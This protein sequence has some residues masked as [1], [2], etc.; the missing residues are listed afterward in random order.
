MK[1][2]PKQNLPNPE[3]T[4]R[5]EKVKYLHSLGKMNNEISLE[6]NIQER[7]VRDD[8]SFMQISCNFYPLIEET[9][10]LKQ[11]IL[12]SILGDGH[13]C[14]LNSR[15]YNSYLS[16]AHSIK[17]KEYFELK[18][19]IL[20]K[21]KIGNQF[22]I[23]N[24]IDPR[25]KDIYTEIRTKSKTHPLFTKYR[26]LFYKDGIKYINKEIIKDLDPFGLAI[27]FMDDGYKYG[28]SYGF[29]TQNFTIEDI[30]F[31]VELLKSKF[32]LNCTIHSNK[33]IYIRKNSANRLTELI[34]TF[35]PNC[36]KYKLNVVYKSDKL[37]E[38]QEVDNQQPIISLND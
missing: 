38:N 5:R 16:F 9:N 32:N 10:E 7:K 26:N 2:L 29:S 1:N 14:K 28:K 19:N 22:Q 3:V 11:F 35:F 24:I 18:Q 37:L 21:Y 13:I 33:S 12:G 23:N 17:Q 31:L 34:K 6:L 30:E 15:N 4:K 27:W 25:F 8:L 20:S 36:M